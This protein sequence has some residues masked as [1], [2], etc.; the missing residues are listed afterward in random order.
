LTSNATIPIVARSFWTTTK[1]NTRNA[2]IATYEF[3]RRNSWGFYL[4]AIDAGRPI[5]TQTINF[6]TAYMRDLFAYGFAKG[7]SGNG[8][9][10]TLDG[11]KAHSRP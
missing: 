4:T 7:S 3:C 8:F 11:M 9:Q 1:A 10:T 2:L 6:D 5:E